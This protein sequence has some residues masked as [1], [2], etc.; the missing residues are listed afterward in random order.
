MHKKFVSN[1]L[2]ILPEHLDAILEFCSLLIS[3]ESLLF[4]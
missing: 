3:H 2:D 4:S 1:V